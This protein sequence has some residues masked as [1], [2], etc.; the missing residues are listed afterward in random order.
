LQHHPF[1]PAQVQ[2]GLGGCSPAEG[3]SWSAV[4]CGCDGLGAVLRQVCAFREILAEKT[5]GVL[6]GSALPG[7]M[8]VAELDRQSGV[9]AQLGMLGHLGALVPGQRA[10]QLSRVRRTAGF[11]G[12]CWAGYIALGKRASSPGNPRDSLAV[13]FVVATLVTSPLL[14]FDSTHWRHGGMPIG[15]IIVLGFI[16]VV[17]NRR[18]RCGHC[19]A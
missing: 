10:A 3:L 1:V 9:D 14:A 17:R 18:N 5:I 6:V 7:A 12:L 19:N 11:A 15:R 4:E 13:G 2:G 16:R 8:G